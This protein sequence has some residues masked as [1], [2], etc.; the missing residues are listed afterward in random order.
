VDSGATSVEEAGMVNQLI[1][2]A[3]GF[4]LTGVVG[5]ALGYFQRTTWA[6]Q[7][8][9]ERRDEERRQAAKIFDE[10]SSLLDRRL[11]RMRRVYWE[12]R[13]CCQGTATGRLPAAVD[14]YRDVLMAWNDNLNRLLALTY[15]HFGG[16]VRR[17]LETEVFEQY[18]SIGRALDEFL[19]QVSASSKGV[20]IPPLGRRLN[21]LGYQVYHLNLRM[22]KLQQQEQ[23]GRD[24]PP[25]V[26]SPAPHHPV[27]QF[28]DSGPA[29]RRLQRALRRAGESP[30]RIDGVFGRNTERALRD[31]QRS[32]ALDP[33]GI[34]G[35]RTWVAL[36]SGAGMPVLREGDR[37]ELVTELQ[38]ALTEYAAQRWETVP[39][40]V[41][42]VFG[43]DTTAAVEAFQRWHGIG[44]DG[45]VG[46]ETWAAELDSAGNTLE[47][48]A[49][50]EYALG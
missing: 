33:D 1:L 40:R 39:E 28:G 43:P 32:R 8:E 22:L 38:A 3:V 45:I 48:R 12:A 13:R 41:D 34:A 19:R 30:G 44:V 9:V 18:A 16:G 6:N 11:Y 17:Q 42:G 50:R 20:E 4:L 21:M 15:T 49:G 26:A 2:L 23:L 29:V 27:L 37:G 31:F 46:D 10:V 14:D 5:S 47:V 7:H 36:P 35:P 25:A 24:A